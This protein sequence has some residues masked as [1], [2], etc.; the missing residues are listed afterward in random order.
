MYSVEVSYFLRV[1]ALEWLVRMKILGKVAA[2]AVL[3]LEI[4]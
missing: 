4:M 3:V 1:I 2:Q